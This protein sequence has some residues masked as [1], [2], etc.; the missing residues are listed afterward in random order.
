MKTIIE[1]KAILDSVPWKRV[2]SHVH[3]HLCDG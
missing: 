2:D 3:T 1:L